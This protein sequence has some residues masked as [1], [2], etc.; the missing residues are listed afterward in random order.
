[1]LRLPNASERIVRAELSGNLCRCTGY[2]GIVSA[3]LAVLRELKE[4]PDSSVEALRQNRTPRHDMTAAQQPFASIG[5]KP[6]EVP[7]AQD[8]APVELKAAVNDRPD[9]Q[10]GEGTSIEEEFTLPFPAEMVWTLMTDL[11]TIAKCLPSAHISSIEA[12]RVKGGLS[13]KFGPMKASFDGVA[14]IS[15]DH[16]DKSATLNG[17][18]QD[19][20]TQSRATG[21][22]T[23]RIE[24]VET[25]QTR[26]RL[27]MLYVLQGPLAQ[28]SRSGMVKDFVRRLIMVFAEN[29]SMTLRSPEEALSGKQQ[30]LRPISLFFSILFDRFRRLFGRGR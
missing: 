28:F 5:F 13:L 29:I 21:K 19:R 9:T 3:I 12:D 30:N 27:S 2:M 22:I 23:Y 20:L 26:V 6:F 25:N 7:R 16:R 15:T 18:G 4:S 10:S 24:T 8:Y 17:A 1:V 14:T 11:P